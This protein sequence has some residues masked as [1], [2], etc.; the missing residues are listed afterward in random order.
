MS[1]RASVNLSNLTLTI[2][3]TRTPHYSRQYMCSSC[4][5]ITFYTYNLHSFIQVPSCALTYL[6]N[7]YTQLKYCSGPYSFGRVNPLS[8]TIP[9]DAYLYPLHPSHSTIFVGAHF[10]LSQWNLSTLQIGT[11]VYLF[12]MFVHG[13]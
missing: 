13:I 6:F 11:V 3:H 9:I 10:Y 2:S 7:I 5:R 8:T 12:I 1:F 4:N